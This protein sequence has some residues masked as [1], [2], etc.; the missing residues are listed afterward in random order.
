MVA[1]CGKTVRL[2]NAPFSTVHSNAMTTV[3]FSNRTDATVTSITGTGG[4]TPV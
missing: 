3:S 1:A 2:L 4:V